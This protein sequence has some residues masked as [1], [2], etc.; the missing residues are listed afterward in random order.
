MLLPRA[1][2]AYTAAL[3]LIKVCMCGPLPA[4][5]PW[6]RLRSAARAP[7]TPGAGYGLRPGAFSFLAAPA[8]RRF[9]VAAP[10]LRFPPLRCAATAARFAP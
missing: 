1:K 7:S 4:R 6:R 10:A 9:R 3:G 8:L 5:N 2:R